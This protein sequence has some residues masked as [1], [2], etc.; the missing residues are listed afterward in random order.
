MIVAVTG[1]TG[2]LGRYIVRHLAEAG[3]SCR[4]WSRPRSDRGGYDDIED[5]ITWVDGDL[6]DESSMR[7]LV[8]GADA[9]VHAALDRPGRGFRGAEGEV[10]AFVERNVVGS[11]RLIEAARAAGAGRFIFI[12]TCAVHEEIL[13][14]RKLDEAH[15]LWPTSH[16]GAHKAAIEKFIHSYGLGEAYDICAIRPT[17]I[18]G[19][20][21]P[22]D[23]SKW[24]EIVRNVKA[25]QPVASAKGGKE[26][27]A[28]DVAR[29]VLV[30]LTAEGV[31]GQAYNCYDLYVAEQDVARIAKDITGSNSDIAALNKGPV[32]Q[33]DTRKI[34]SLGVEFGGKVQLEATVGEMLEWMD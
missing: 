28:A 17:G 34:R 24:Y 16:Y 25:G 5:R 1:A 7:E 8:A 29:A 9:V 14:D 22:L 11:L 4:C 21:R 30:L 6:S 20:A 26:V 27:H 15:P 3:H 18:Y 13:E 33:I 31:A 19:V 23:Q 32:H 10:P 12:S 2:F